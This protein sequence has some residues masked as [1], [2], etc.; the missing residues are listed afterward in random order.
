M[1]VIVIESRFAGN[2]NAV[3][4]PGGRPF[5]GRPETERV[6]EFNVADSGFGREHWTVLPHLGRDSMAI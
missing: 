5:P 2:V 1:N 4:N 6:H 3:G